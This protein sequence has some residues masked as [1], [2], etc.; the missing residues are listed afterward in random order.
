MRVQFTRSARRH[1]IGKAHA[2]AAIANAGTPVVLPNGN[3]EWT[4]DDDRGIELHIVAFI[5]AEDHDLALVKHVF[6]T[7]LKGKTS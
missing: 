2:L 1:K 7:A 5:A 6:P 4:G 3:L